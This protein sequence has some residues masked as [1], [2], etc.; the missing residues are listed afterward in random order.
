MLIGISRVV[1]AGEAATWLKALDAGIAAAFFA[2]WLRRIL[3]SARPTRY[4]LRNSWEILTF[5]PFTLLSGTL[6]GGDIVRGVRLVRILRFA[7]LGRFAKLSVTLARLPRRA[8][9]LQRVARNAR[10]VNLFLAGLLTVSVGAAV[11]LAVERA[12]LGGQ[13]YAAAFWWSLNIFTTVGYAVPHPQTPAGFVTTGA[14]M[15]SG[16]A[17]VGVFTASLASAILRT[18][19]DDGGDA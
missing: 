11:L 17:F 12:A 1:D 4:T 15:V 8:R 2:D 9:H 5:I 14:L 19:D 18:P 10:L 7:R 3:R 6:A 16:V 13:G